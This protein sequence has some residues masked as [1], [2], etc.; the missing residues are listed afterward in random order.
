MYDGQPI[1]FKGDSSVYAVV[2]MA[3]ENN[4]LYQSVFVQDPTGGLQLRLSFSGG[5][6]E[7]DSIRIYL[8]GTTLSQY[9]GL[10]QLDSVNVDENVIKQATNK[11][12]DPAKIS[13]RE[14]G[15]A[16]ESQIIELS[17]VEFVKEDLGKTYAD[18]ENQESKNRTITNCKGH[19]IIVRTSG[20]ANFA[21][22][23]LPRGNGSLIAAL[24]QFG[25]TYQLFIRRPSEV[26]LDST[27]CN[28]GSCDARGTLNEDFSNVSTSNRIDLNCW[29]NKSTQGD[30]LWVGRS[31]GSN[32]YAEATSYNAVQD[33]NVMWLVTPEI[34]YSS[35]DQLSFRSAVEDYSHDGLTV[36]IATDFNGNEISGASWKKVNATVANGSSSGWESASIS[37]SNQISGG[38]YHV[39]FRYNGSKS[40]AYD[41]KYKIDDVQITQ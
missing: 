24:G 16:Y 8:K 37:V 20:Y 34:D 39:A 6:Y 14:I 10:L 35:S 29:T 1:H 13:I 7:G 36:W 28:Q 17:G 5:L 11:E 21:D 38:T 32:K 4:N 27:R 33:S 2:G 40:Q 23:T 31:S 26:K 41:S 15:E 22:D 9:N 3:E 30:R 18:A 19:T 25:S 12:V